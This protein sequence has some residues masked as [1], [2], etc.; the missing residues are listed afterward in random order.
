MEMVLASDWQW[1]QGRTVFSQFEN[2]RLMSRVLAEGEGML[3]SDPRDDAAFRARM[4]GIAGLEFKPEAPEYPVWRNYGRLFQATLLATASPVSGRERRLVC[5]SLCRALAEDRVESVNDYILH[6]AK[7][8]YLPG[9]VF[10]LNKHRPDAP[11]VFP[12]CA[13]M[14]LLLAKASSGVD[15]ISPADVRDYLLGAGLLG[16]EDWEHYTVLRKETRQ[17]ERES[18]ERQIREMMIFVSQATFL[19]WE[20]GSGFLQ[21]DFP[22]RND[23]SKLKSMFAEISP[24]EG[25]RN[26]DVVE[27]ILSMGEWQNPEFPATLFAPSVVVADSGL[28][29][30]GEGIRRRANHLIIERSSK[31]REMYFARTESPVCDITDNLPSV[32]FPWAENLLEIHHVMPLSSSTRINDEGETLMDDLVALTPSGHRAVHVFYRQWLR[33]NR[34]DDFSSRDEAWHVYNEAKQKYRAHHGIST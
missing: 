34:K 4:R 15:S 9:P 14:R 32:G 8:F 2:L 22:H 23:E 5:T 20:A 3:V 26:K 12:L 13:I 29:V 16:N 30:P 6:V 33:K 27:E 25:V 18:Q 24:I 1:E 11:R 28:I 31:L 21:L 19:K 10:G 7:A 17:W